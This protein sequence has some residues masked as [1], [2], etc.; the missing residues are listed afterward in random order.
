MPMSARSAGD[1]AA[2][3]DREHGKLSVCPHK[4]GTEEC[5]QWHRGYTNRWFTLEEEMDGE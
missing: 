3:F 2:Q 5:A 4:S 1:Y